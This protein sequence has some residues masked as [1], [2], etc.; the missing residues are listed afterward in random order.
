MCLRSIT[1]IYFS[2]AG[3]QKTVEYNHIPLI[4]WNLKLASY[5]DSHEKEW[6]H[7]SGSDSLSSERHF[8][9]FQQFSGTL[10][11]GEWGFFWIH[12]RRR[13]KGICHYRLLRAYLS[14]TN[15]FAKTVAARLYQG[16]TLFSWGKLPL[17]NNSLNFFILMSTVPALGLL[18][19][20][21]IQSIIV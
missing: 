4:C 7:T 11:S 12:G 5:L 15:T 16:F 13:Q 19:A 20:F 6:D 9:A 2:Q 21:L 18:C 14:Y 3:N 1:S 17:W 10:G 8:C